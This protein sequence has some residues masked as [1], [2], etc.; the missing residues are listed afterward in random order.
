MKFT[1]ME[2]GRFHLYSCFIKNGANVQKEA[3]EVIPQNSCF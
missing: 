2:K 3:A 1:R